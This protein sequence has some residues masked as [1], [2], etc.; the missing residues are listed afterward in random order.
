MERVISSKRKTNFIVKDSVLSR[1]NFINS[2]TIPHISHH[3][4]FLL[5]QAK[6]S[7]IPSLSVIKFNN[8]KFDLQ[9]IP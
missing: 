3:H 2:I 8:T 6:I 5:Q 1:R 9:F 4:F 7:Y